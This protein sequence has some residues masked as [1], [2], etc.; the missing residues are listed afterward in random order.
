MFTMRITISV[1]SHE[2]CGTLKEYSVESY[3]TCRDAFKE[4]EMD[5]HGVKFLLLLNELKTSQRAH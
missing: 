1:C 2:T 4:L 5:L 3:S